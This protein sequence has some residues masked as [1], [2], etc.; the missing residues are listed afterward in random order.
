M[1]A[2]PYSRSSTHLE[3]LGL[4]EVDHQKVHGKW[5]VPGPPEMDPFLGGSWMQPEAF[6]SGMPRAYTR[7]GASLMDV[8]GVADSIFNLLWP[9]WVIVVL[10]A[11]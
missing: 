6:H 1:H 7:S 4:P 10:Y 2:N 11:F 8:S 5:L 3:V 9:F